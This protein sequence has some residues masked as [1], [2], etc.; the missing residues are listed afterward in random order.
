MIT[1]LLKIFFTFSLASKPAIVKLKLKASSKYF[2]ENLFH[3]LQNGILC[4]I[5]AYAVQ[6]ANSIRE[7]IS[8][9]IV[10]K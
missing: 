9:L 8:T 7:L 10:L 4:V 3:I 6:I 5:I 1:R 2:L